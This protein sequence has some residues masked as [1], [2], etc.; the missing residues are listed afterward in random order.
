[1]HFSE[2]IMNSVSCLRQ[3]SL[4]E[5]KGTHTQSDHIFANL[6]NLENKRMKKNY[7]LNLFFSTFV[8]SLY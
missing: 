4:T 5:L 8:K 2:E 1:M 7:L 3:S 6:S